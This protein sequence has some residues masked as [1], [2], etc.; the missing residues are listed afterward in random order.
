MPIV[1]SLRKGVVQPPSLNL[2]LSEL[3]SHSVN[4]RQ[5]A[6]SLKFLPE[7]QG[8]FL[9]GALSF[10][11]HETPEKSSFLLGPL[12]QQSDRQ[13]DRQLRVFLWNIFISAR[14]TQSLWLLL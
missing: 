7:R 1:G 10:L 4:S 3:Q 6:R 8:P 5:A 9:A 13:T 14:L 12:F 2:F 11:G